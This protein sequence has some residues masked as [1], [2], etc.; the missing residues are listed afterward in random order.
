[1]AMGTVCAKR[2]KCPEP[3]DQGRRRRKYG[4]REAKEVLT[5]RRSPSVPSRN[6]CLYWYTTRP[7][8]SMDSE[9]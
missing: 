9:V 2:K 8:P 1:M 7:R 6:G 4:F 3:A 5:E